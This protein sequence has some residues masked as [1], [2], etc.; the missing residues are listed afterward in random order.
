MRILHQSV[1]GP[2]TCHYLP[3]RRATQEYVMVGQLSPSE[4]EDLMN[5][6]WRKFGPMLFHPICGGCAECR[7]I[8]IPA[9]GF[10]P[11]RSQR[12]TW[13]RNA[14]LT[15]RYAQPTVDAARM[16]LYRRYHA[17]QAVYKGWPDMDRT[18]KGYAFQFV[19]SPLPAVEISVWE[20]DLLRAVALTDITPNVVSGVY[21][22]HEPDCRQRG[23]GTFAMLHTIELARRLGRRW[24][25]FGYY[26]AG[27]ASMSYKTKFRPCEI[28]GTDGVWRDSQSIGLNPASEPGTMQVTPS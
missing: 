15:V 18:E 27:C 24:A 14:D 1:S 10:T 25:Y 5:R 13:Q 26:V 16:D 9:E 7:P 4:Y 22:F 17:A 23:L 6:G 21:H 20:G 2:E 8:R 11:D 28:L 19:R 12:R 3:D